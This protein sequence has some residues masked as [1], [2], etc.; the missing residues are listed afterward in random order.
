M[1]SSKLEGRITLDYIAETLGE[2]GRRSFLDDV[3]K[4]GYTDPERFY[5]DAL[6]FMYSWTNI[7]NVFKRASR[8][9]D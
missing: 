1:T 5:D 7:S 8:E 4:K 3:R 9:C 6:K 2:E